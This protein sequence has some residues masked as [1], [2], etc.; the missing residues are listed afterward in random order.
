MFSTAITK[1]WFLADLAILAAVRAVAP[2]PDTL[3]VLG[4]AITRGK[5][6]GI[7]T[8]LVTGFEIGFGAGFGTSL[9]TGLGTVLGTGS[10][11]LSATF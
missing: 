7:A 5:L 9:G 10:L 2:R 11:V 4:N 1:P 8:S 3:L 6:T